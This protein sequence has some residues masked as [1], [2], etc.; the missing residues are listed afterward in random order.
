MAGGAGAG[1]GPAAARVRFGLE[2]LRP[3]AGRVQL[4]GSAAER[5]LLDQVTSG[6]AGA[7][8]LA[9]DLSLPAA[10]ALIGKCRVLVGNDTGLLHMARAVGT[11]VVGIYGSTTPLW[12]GPAPREGVALYK[13][14]SCSPCFQRECPLRE[15]RLACLETIEV[16]EVTQAVDRL[17]AAGIGAV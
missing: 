12:S 4:L 5:P 2:R 9:G 1:E 14:L 6:V 10:A 15:G 13:G 17:L 3:D 7:S 11:P 8:A 16:E